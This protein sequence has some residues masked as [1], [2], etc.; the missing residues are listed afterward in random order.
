VAKRGGR[1]RTT[2]LREVLNAILYLLRTGCQ[3]RT[4]PRDFPPKST[5]NGYLQQFWGRGVWGRIW[6][7]LLTA[8]R[9]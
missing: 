1:R 5:V 6:A 9:E 7:T 4:L 8:A 2:D 3:W